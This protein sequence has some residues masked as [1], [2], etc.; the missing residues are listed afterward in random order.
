[1]MNKD[2]NYPPSCEYTVKHNEELKS[3]NIKT[4]LT[5]KHLNSDKHTYIPPS[6]ELI[7]ISKD[8]SNE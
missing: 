8:D 5:N 7:D 4:R 2:N 6:C 1:M 3:K